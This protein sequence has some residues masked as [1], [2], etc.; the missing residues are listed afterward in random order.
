MD[1]LLPSTRTTNLKNIPIKVY[2]PMSNCVLQTLVPPVI[3]G[4][5]NEVQTVGTALQK[6]MSDLFPS[7]R[8][9]ILARPILHGIAIPMSTPLVDLLYQAMYVDGFLHISI[10]MMS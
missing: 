10:V 2:L 3:S 6:H 5:E 8:T 9:C 7:R 1:K 4:T